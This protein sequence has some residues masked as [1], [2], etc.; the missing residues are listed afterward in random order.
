MLL[1]IGR[2][3]LANAHNEQNIGNIKFIAIQFNRLNFILLFFAD[4]RVSTIY[5]Y[6]QS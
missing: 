6:M 3:R 4:P 5:V 2:N 1:T